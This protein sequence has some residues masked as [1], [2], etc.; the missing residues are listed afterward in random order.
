MK[1]LLNKREVEIS[2]DM[3]FVADLL[4]AE[5]LDG[6]GRAVAVNNKVMPKADLNSLRL[7]D[8]M[9]IIVIKA[10]CGG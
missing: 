9:K 6:P 1:V 4:K 8:G 5:S 2:P 3:I 7:E 10:V